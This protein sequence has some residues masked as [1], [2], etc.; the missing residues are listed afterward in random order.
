MEAIRRIVRREGNTLTIELPADFQAQT[1][2]LIILPADNTIDAIPTD[3]PSVDEVAQEGL[4][5]FQRYL[6]TWPTMS[7]GEYNDYLSKKEGFREW[8]KQ[9]V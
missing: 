5:D 6:L 4:T 9:S 8:T 3:K 2:E 7:E 1:V